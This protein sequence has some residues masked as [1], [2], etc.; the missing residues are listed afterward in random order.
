MLASFHVQ[1]QREIAPIAHKG[2]METEKEQ[3][4]LVAKVLRAYYRAQKYCFPEKG[5]SMYK[6]MKEWG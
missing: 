3:Q 1:I 6:E 4:N 2:G 5:L